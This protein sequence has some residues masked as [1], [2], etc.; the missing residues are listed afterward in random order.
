MAFVLVE[1]QFGGQV[2]AGPAE[3]HEQ[4]N[5]PG[6]NQ[7]ERDGALQAVDRLQLEGLNAAA[8]LEDVEEDLDIPSR[9]PL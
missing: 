2:R 9:M 6:N 4:R 1:E 3:S 7:V 8:V 5:A